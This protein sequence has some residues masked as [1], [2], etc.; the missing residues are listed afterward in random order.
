MADWGFRRRGRF[1]GLV[2]VRLRRKEGGS[3]RFVLGVE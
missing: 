3:V 1:V 2:V